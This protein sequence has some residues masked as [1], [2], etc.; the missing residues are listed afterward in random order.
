MAAKSLRSNLQW[1]GPI[2]RNRFTATIDGT[3]SRNMN[4]PGTVDLN[5]IRWRGSRW[6]TKQGAR[7]TC[8]REHR[9]VT[10]AVSPRDARLTQRFSA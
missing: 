10:G 7:Y 8:S 2:L 3:Y 6:Q 5:L 4:Q 9:S 1:S